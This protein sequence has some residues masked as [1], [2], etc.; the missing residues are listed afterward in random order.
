MDALL[1]ARGAG[2]TLVLALATAASAWILTRWVTA[3]LIR[4]AMFDTPNQRSSH[5]TP[6]PRG[7]GIAVLAVAL[8]LIATIVWL[9][10]PGDRVAWAVLGSTL[11][12]AIV[13]GLDDRSGL[14][15]TTRLFTH[16]ACVAL[17]L[18]FIPAKFTLFQGLLPVALDRLV[19]GLAWI[20]FVNLY[21]FMDG[22]DGLAGVETASIGL[23]VFA[24]VALIGTQGGDSATVAGLGGLILAAAACGFLVLNWHPARVFLGDVGAIPLGFLLGWLLLTLALWGYWVAALTLP[25][26]Y[27][28]DSGITIAARA[29]RGERIWQ[30]HAGHFYQRAVQRGW[31]HARVARFVGGGNVMLVA[32]A[33]FS[34]QV[35]N[36]AGDLI[37]LGG[38][39]LIV[40]LM[41][42]WLA[43][44]IPPGADAGA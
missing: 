8:P 2:L 21:N 9:Y 7:G 36:R 24:L 10:R 30:A 19:A 4:R 12:L 23:G 18:A 37:C 25:A 20:W 31:S 41:L 16:A 32:L 15:I 6:I 39:A 34:T 28:A 40:A 22:I 29:L 44:A 43:R 17:V 35:V 42:A 3:W 13:S 1:T 26:Y 33:A 11:A 5:L 27:L 14:P 38:A